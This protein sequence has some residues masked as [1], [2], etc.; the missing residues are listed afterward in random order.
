MP[1]IKLS[2]PHQAERMPRQ[3]QREQREQREQQGHPSWQ[4]HSIEYRIDTQLQGPRLC[5]SVSCFCCAPF[6]PATVP[7]NSGVALRA[8][9]R[10]ANCQTLKG[11]SHDAQIRMHFADSHNQRRR[12][13]GIRQR[14]YIGFVR[15]ST[16]ESLP[17]HEATIL[18]NVRQRTQAPRGPRCMLIHA[19]KTSFPPC[20]LS[21]I[22]F[23]QLT[24][25]AL[26]HVQDV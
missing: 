11:G 16:E 24:D 21:A 22:Q 17:T 7:S 6:L 14:P 5:V 9:R 12:Q 8:R 13:A 25:H 3:E 4:H 10:K 26:T 2:R 18:E 20:P 1:R 19:A 23:P 15:K